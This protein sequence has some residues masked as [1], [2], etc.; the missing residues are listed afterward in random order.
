M[1][2]RPR[3]ATGWP[4]RLAF[5]VAPGAIGQIEVQ[6]AQR[7]LLP[8]SA[9]ASAPLDLE[10]APSV[11]ARDTAAIVVAWGQSPPGD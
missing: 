3:A 4:V 1:T 5:R 2:L 6:A 10:L 11:Y 7:V 9:T 8:V